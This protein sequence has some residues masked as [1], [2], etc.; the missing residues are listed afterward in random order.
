MTISMY[1]ASIPVMMRSINN[2]IGIIEKGA[3]H[4]EAKKIDPTVLI[5]SRLYPDMLPLVKQVQIVS[6]IARRGAARLAGLE[7]PA[8]TDNETTFDELIDRLKNTNTYLSTLTATQIDGS[9]E[10]LITLPIGKDKTM[11][12]KGLA[13]LLGFVQ[14]NVYFHVTTAY[15]ILRHSGVE[16]GKLDFLG[17]P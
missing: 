12:F 6:D 3:A 11:E 1:Q 2:L 15:N 5:N 9:E 4:A 10:K 8:M 16:L 13:Y 7:A 17:K 14:P